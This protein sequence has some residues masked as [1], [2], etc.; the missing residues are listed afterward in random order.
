[1]KNM[2]TVLLSILA[3]GLTAFGVVKATAPQPVSEPTTVVT[4]AA[5]N[6]VEYRTVNLAD[7]DYPD[8]TYAAETAVESVV[9]VEVTVQSQSRS[10]DPFEFFFGFGNGYGFGQPRE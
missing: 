3:G 2:T 6:T 10:I 8:F 1:M 7:S 4:D 5:G 9:Y